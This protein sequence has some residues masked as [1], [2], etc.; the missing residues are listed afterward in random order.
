M[1]TELFTEG[2]F[3]YHVLTPRHKDAAHAVL[4]RAFCSE[5]ACKDVAEIRPEMET[6]F[7]DWLEFVDYWME[8]CATNGLSVV[9]LNRKDSRE[10]P[11]NLLQQKIR[12]HRDREDR[13]QMIF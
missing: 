7:I 11:Y 3:S 2:D 8:H 13:L 10:Y 9:A 4:A 1:S 12:Q 6:K 5:P